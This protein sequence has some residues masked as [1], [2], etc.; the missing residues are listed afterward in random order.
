MSLSGYPYGVYLFLFQ[1]WEFR[2]GTTW[3]TE[4]AERTKLNNNGKC[5][6]YMNASNHT[7]C[8][9]LVYLKCY[10]ALLYPWKHCSIRSAWDKRKQINGRVRQQDEEYSDI[11][12]VLDVEVV[13]WYY[14]KIDGC[15]KHNSNMQLLDDYMVNKLWGRTTQNLERG[16]IE[17]YVKS[18]NSIK[19]QC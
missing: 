18:N 19:V 8:S 16:S 3:I 15:V 12:W 2:N 13:T 4:K 1:L 11:Y 10:T 9:G 17:I 7:K 5:L 6:W 14:Q